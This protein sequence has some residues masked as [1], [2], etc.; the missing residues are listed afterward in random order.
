MRITRRGL[1]GTAAAAGLL[2]AVGC[3]GD[4]PDTGEGALTVGLTYIPNIQF[5]PFYVAHSEGIFA[6]H[7]L[8]V[9]L[10]H[11]GEQEDLFTALLSD[12]EQVVHASTAEAVVAAAGGQPLQTF[13]TNYQRYP[14]VIITSSPEITE[15]GQLAGA[16]IG[17]PGRYGSNYYALQAALDQ[18]GMT[19]AD[20]KIVEV[21]YTQVTALT[22]GEVAAV[23]AYR[24][25]ELVQVEAMG[26]AHSVV[27]VVSESAPVLVGPGLVSTGESVSNDQARALADAVEEA[28]KR[29]IED[30]ELALRA[31]EEHVPTLTQA[32]QREQARAVLE[33]T[34]EMWQR[35]GRVTTDVDAETIT[36]MGEFLTYVGVIDEP[37]ADVVRTV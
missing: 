11:H 13:A 7:G 27:E 1:L 34:M 33:A 21:G 12:Q 31:T 4:E 20:V 16:S 22:S 35:D 24:N 2:G 37:P 36:R 6:D 19:E 10:R 23:V 5:S 29:I 15:M 17:L 32:E 26:A 3:A 9:T 30:P 8:D 25:N 18:A 14:V 28:E